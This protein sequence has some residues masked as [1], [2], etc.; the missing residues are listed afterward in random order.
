[1]Q[2]NGCSCL[3]GHTKN[4]QPA[5]VEN[6]SLRAGVRQV[7]SVGHIRT[8]SAGTVSGAIDCGYRRDTFEHTV[9]GSIS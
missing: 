4:P 2:L 8:K 3:G 9:S 1:M 6:N 7:C 5:S